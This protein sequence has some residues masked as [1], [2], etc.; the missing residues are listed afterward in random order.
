MGVKHAREYEDILAELTAAVAL[1]PGCYEFFEMTEEEWVRLNEADR[2]EVL[3]ALADDV[4]YGLGE[5]KI[6][7][8]GR[9]EI[10]YDPKFHLI[11]IS[12]GDQLLSMIK[13]T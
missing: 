9:A 1:I 4:F 3:E 6:I 13:L 2:K 11:D 5:D 7:E 12:M 8:V 10:T